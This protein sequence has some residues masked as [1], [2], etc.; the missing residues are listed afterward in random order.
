MTATTIILWAVQLTLVPA[1]SP[2]FV[3]IVRKVKARLQN[4]MGASVFQ[5]YRDL[6]KLMRKDEVISEDASWIFRF[7]PYLV[8]SVTLILG[9]SIPLFATIFA[10]NLLGDLLAII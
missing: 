9:A 5:P 10:A 3:G 1:L 7:A 2:L 8:F 4:R 6:A